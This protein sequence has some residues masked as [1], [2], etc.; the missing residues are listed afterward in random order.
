[1]FC[2]AM[3]FLVCC[4][5]VSVGNQKKLKFGTKA[6]STCGRTSTIVV[7][8]WATAN[9]SSSRR[10]VAECSKLLYK[11]GRKISLG[12]FFPKFWCYIWIF[13][14]IW[15]RIQISSVG[16]PKSAK[17]PLSSYFPPPPSF[18]CPPLWS[19]FNIVPASGFGGFY[20]MKNSE[21][22]KLEERVS[23]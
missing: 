21:W 20:L 2:L 15:K 17:T 6:T 13:I 18:L 22:G 11:I 19:V 7:S 3:K 8:Q 12:Y 9:S 23:T 16:V 5:T 10:W 14:F 4:S 1:M